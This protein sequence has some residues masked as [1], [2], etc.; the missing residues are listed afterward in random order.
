MFSVVR[1]RTRVTADDQV[2]V[3]VSKA[4]ARVQGRVPWQGRGSG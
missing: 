4:G 1:P 2:K 3:R